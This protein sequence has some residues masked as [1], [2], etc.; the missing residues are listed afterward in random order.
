TSMLPSIAMGG[1]HG[2]RCVRVRYLD[3]EIALDDARNEIT[4]GR[5][6]ENSIVQKGALISRLHARIELARGR[7]LLVDQST[8]GT[9]VL[10]ADGKESFVRRDSVVLQG[11]GCIGLGKMPDPNAA[12]VIRFALEE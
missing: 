7:F 5:A 12:D 3:S 8:N 10:N 11:E 6:E 1:M 2:A 4:M 9:F